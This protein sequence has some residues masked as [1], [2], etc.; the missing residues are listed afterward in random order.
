[1]PEHHFAGKNN[2]AGIDFIEIGVFRSRSMRG[3]ENRVAR[4]LFDIAGGR[5]A[6][7][8]DLRGQRIG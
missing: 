1:M 5:D 8:T 6:N 2:G 7:T 4:H 3:F